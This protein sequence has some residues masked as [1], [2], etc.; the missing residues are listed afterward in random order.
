[1]GNPATAGGDGWHAIFWAF[2]LLST[3]KLLGLAAVVYAS[4]PG[5]RER[6]TIMW[7]GSERLGFVQLLA[8]WIVVLAAL[9]VTAFHP[10]P[11]VR[12]GWGAAIA[13]STS[14]E[15]LFFRLCG[16][17]MSVL[18]MLSLL[19]VK[20]WKSDVSDSMKHQTYLAAGIFGVVLLI[21][22][23]PQGAPFTWLA[24]SIELYHLAWL[25]FICVCFIVV[26]NV[27][28]SGVTLSP[29]PAQFNFW[30]L[31]ALTA[32]KNLFS[33]LPKRKTVGWTPQPATKKQNIVLLVDESIRGDYVSFAPGNSLTPGLAALSDEF[34]C[35]GPT[36]SGGNCSSYSNVI[37]RFGV[38]LEQ[39]VETAKTN[40]SVFAYAK[41][42]GYRTV[43]IDAQAGYQA[44]G[45]GT[46]NFMTPA[47]KSEIDGFYVVQIGPREKDA[48]FKMA[49]IIAA[50]LKAHQA[51]FIYANKN[52]VH[53]PYEDRYPKGEEVYAPRQQNSSANPGSSMIA[54]YRNGVHY[55][56]EKFMLYLFAKADLSNATLIYTSDHG[57][58][59]SP[60]RY[61]HGTI[62]NPD[63]RTGLVPLWAYS[64]NKD[65]A[66]AFAKGAAKSR[67]R[68]SH[69]LI[70]PTLYELMGYAP[71]DIAVAYEASMFTGT[72]KAPRMTT[73][74]IF[75]LFGASALF[76]DI[77]LQRDYF[78]HDAQPKLK[79]ERHPSYVQGSDQ[80]LTFV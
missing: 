79:I 47:E 38:T 13:I 66:T 34:T 42:A 77:D 23:A 2:G 21:M 55:V 44:K 60:G 18:D 75:G 5:T 46:Q 52:G 3:L 17:Q 61:P 78:E 76:W 72:E 45:T 8:E 35:F 58:L 28:K 67:G 4:N 49:D 7:A 15:W 69:F 71:A 26:E 31:L 80:V 36:V 73:G 14:A 63:P 6:F 12:L 9:V 25:P 68:A 43:Y 50:E 51:V 59:F 29:M 19:A 65:T 11:I 74:D 40:P 27:Q 33:P 1:M 41:H 64:S 16:S 54:A 48:D 10:D 30:A 53:Y 37:L 57:Q 56:V 20:N 32:V 22:A 24:S 62:R 70:A 39:I